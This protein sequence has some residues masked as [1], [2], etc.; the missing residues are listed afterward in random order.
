MEAQKKKISKHG[1]LINVA[2]YDSIRD[3]EKANV[4]NTIRYQKYLKNKK[5]GF[6]ESLAEKM[7]T[8]SLA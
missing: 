7:V 5:S 4:E 6:L 8:D 2:L 3:P 1:P